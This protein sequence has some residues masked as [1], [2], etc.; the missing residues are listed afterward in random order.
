MADWFEIRVQDTG[1]GIAESDLP[2]LFQ[3]F[4][5]AATSGSKKYGGTGLGLAISQKLCGLMG[6][7]I[8]CVSEIGRG[9]TFIVRIPA[10]LSR[11]LLHASESPESAEP[12]Q[13][14][15]LAPA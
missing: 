14:M 6:G 5:Q 15:V 2:N 8:S 13:P 10:R 11:D 7:G 9:S 1:I 12:V 4:G 3:N